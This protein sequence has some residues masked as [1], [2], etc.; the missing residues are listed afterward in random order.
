MMERPEFTPFGQINEELHKHI[1]EEMKYEVESINEI[2]EALQ[3]LKHKAKCKTDEIQKHMRQC[4]TCL[5]LQINTDILIELPEYWQVR[6]EHGGGR[7]PKL[8]Y[9]VN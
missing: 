8:H 3:E 5:S 4:G 1:L 6:E 7:Y 2:Q 9:Q